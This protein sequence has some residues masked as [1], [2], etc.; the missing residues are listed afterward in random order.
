MGT[1]WN[2]RD[3]APRFN[4]TSPAIIEQVLTKSAKEPS[5][6]ASIAFWELANSSDCPLKNMK[7][8]GTPS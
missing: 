4:V 2:V 5:R 6:H 3:Y 1:G 7:Q 8:I